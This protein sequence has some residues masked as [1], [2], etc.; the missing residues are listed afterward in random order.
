MRRHAKSLIH[1]IESTIGNAC[2]GAEIGVWRGHTSAALLG[3]FPALWLYCV[4]PWEEGGGHK[5]MP[6]ELGELI[7]GREEFYRITD[8]AGDRRIVCSV[9]SD[10]AVGM[11]RDDSLDFVFI[12]GEHTY[13]CVKQDIGL[14][15]PKVRVGG[16]L[17]GHDYDGKGDH[18]GGFGVKRAVD[19][20]LAEGMGYTVGVAPALIWWVVKR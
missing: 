7:A 15:L 12:D 6:K 2:L 3:R 4:D 8:F 11:V 19:E 16:L 9:E 10:L 1:L 20:V 18:H 14:W 5:T 17:C 13:D